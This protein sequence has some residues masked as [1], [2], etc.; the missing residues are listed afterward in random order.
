MLLDRSPLRGYLSIQAFRHPCTRLRARIREQSTFFSTTVMTNRARSCNARGYWLASQCVILHRHMRSPLETCDCTTESVA[1]P[2]T[3]PC[4]PTIGSNNYRV[5]CAT[6]D[7]DTVRQC[8]STAAKCAPHCNAS[9]K[10]LEHPS[11]WCTIL[12]WSALQDHVQPAR[13]H[14]VGDTCTVDAIRKRPV[15]YGCSI[16]SNHAAFIG[17]PTVLKGRPHPGMNSRY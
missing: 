9:Q 8:H 5:N 6:I 15:E 14:A 16:W 10:S 1:V 3:R 17:A 13:G 7:G 2:A 4:S 11:P 12:P